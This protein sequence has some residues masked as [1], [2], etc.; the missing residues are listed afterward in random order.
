MM[1][2][3]PDGLCTCGLAH[4]LVNVP[5]RVARRLWIS[6]ENGA[7]CRMLHSLRCDGRV[8]YVR[9]YGVRPNPWPY[10]N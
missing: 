5:V 2:A 6:L 10:R 7:A 3:C 9:V 1:H 4:E 8:G